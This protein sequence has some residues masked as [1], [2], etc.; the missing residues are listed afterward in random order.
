MRLSKV[1]RDDLTLCRRKSGKGFSYR[2]ADGK[3]VGDAATRDRI[4]SLGIPPAWRDVRIAAKANAHI[5]VLGVDEAG[6]DQYIYHPEWELRR[7][8]KKQKRLSALTAVLPR[9]RKKIAEA[10]DAETG[11][12]ELALAIAVALI[13]RTAMR[14]GREKY[15]ETSGTRGAGTLYARDV[16]VTGDEVCMNFDAKG[17]KR[18]EYCLTDPSLA[19]AVSRIKTLPGKRLLVYRNEAGKIRPIKTGAINDFLRDLAG[20]EISAK[21][22]RTLHASALAGEALAEMEVGTSETA[23]RR[24]MAQVAKQVSDVLRNTPTI[25]RKS[26][27]APCLFKLFDDGKLS[28]LWNAAGKGRTGLLAREKRLGV[29][30]ASVT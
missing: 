18:A 1:T 17:G 11:S 10:L 6:R 19:Q 9:L 30:L 21:D 13:D 28:A 25:C 26:Y 23:R 22:F 27:I 4:R 3:L 12:R 16:R 14:V 15:L 20:V 7:D 29:V 24:Q 8:G 2:D 5:Q